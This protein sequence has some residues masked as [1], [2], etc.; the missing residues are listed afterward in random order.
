MGVTRLEISS[1]CRDAID[2]VHVF[3]R[4]RPRSGADIGLD[5]LRRR[6]AGNYARHRRP[7]QQPTESELQQT[8]SARRAERAEA[9]D[10]GPVRFGQIALGLTRRGLYLKLRRLGFE[11]TP[12]GDSMSIARATDRTKRP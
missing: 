6:R 3:A 11:T 12:F 1:V 8:V 5:L 9:L 2:L 4:R 10:G 7:A